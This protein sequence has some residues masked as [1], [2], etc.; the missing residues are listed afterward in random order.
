M[1]SR[2]ATVSPSRQRRLRGRS[3]PTLP[4]S[5]CADLAPV[6]V[7]A[8]LAGRD[9]PYFGDS[10][11][12]LAA[13]HPHSRQA[14]RNLRPAR[15]L[16]PGTKLPEAHVRLRAPEADHQLLAPASGGRW[17]GQLL[18]PFAPAPGPARAIRR[19]RCRG[20]DRAIATT[21]CLCPGPALAH[22]RA[23]ASGRGI[24]RP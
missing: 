4:Y 1:C 24:R 9:F 8:V 18:P 20:Y 16:R 19:V 12:S 15:R 17:L 11:G 23:P 10:H 5:A 21:T 6:P 22:R 7:E 13:A 14:T 2:K 3:L